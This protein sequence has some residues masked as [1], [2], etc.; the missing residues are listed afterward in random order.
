MKKV[1]IFG[2]RGNKQSIE[3]VLNQRAPIDD[4]EAD[5]V[6]DSLGVDAEPTKEEM[7]QHLEFIKQSSVYFDATLAEAFDKFKEI[8][9][10]YKEKQEV[11]LLLITAFNYSNQMLGNYKAYLASPMPSHVDAIAFQ[12]ESAERQVMFDNY[13]DAYAMVAIMRERIELFEKIE[14]DYQEAVKLET[15]VPTREGKY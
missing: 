9:K 14:A 10:H 5:A 13:L 8:V 4:T 2:S 15:D 3:D 11:R 1:A 12:A 6:A 7:L